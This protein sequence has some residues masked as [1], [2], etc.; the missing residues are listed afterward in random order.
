MSGAVLQLAGRRVGIRRL[1]ALEQLGLISLA[2]QCALLLEPFHLPACD[3]TA[4]AHN[5][6]LLCTAADLGCESPQALLDTFSL[7]ELAELAQAAWAV[8]HGSLEGDFAKE[9]ANHEP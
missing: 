4:I 1:S 2:E 6:A 8:Q 3:V 5:A 7:D 9:E